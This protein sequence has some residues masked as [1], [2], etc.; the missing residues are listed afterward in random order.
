MIRIRESRARMRGMI[1][2]LIAAVL[3]A[4]CVGDKG[5]APSTRPASETLG[6]ISVSPMN[7][8]MAVGETLPVTT[9]GRSIA[10]AEMTDF[11]SL[12]YQF[13]NAN[14]TGHVHI[15]ASGV[16]TA[17]SASDFYS[18]IRIS[19]FAFKDGVVA[20]DQA[21]IQVVE[22]AFP[23]PTL[24]IAPIAPDSAKM[25]WGDSK[26]L[27]P[28]IQNSASASIPSPQLRLEYGPG[29][30][31]TMQC[32]VPSITATGVLRTPQLQ[33]TRCGQNGNAGTV[34]LNWIHAFTK[35]TAWVHAHV[36]VFGVALHDSVQFTIS[37]PYS[38]GVDVGTSYT[39]SSTH[40]ERSSVYISPGGM[41]YFFNDFN[42]V[43][44]TSVVFTFEHPEA[45]LASDPPATDGGTEGNVSAIL[46]YG[47][48][49][50]KI[51]TPGVYHWT[52]TVSGGIPPYTGAIVKG[53]ITVE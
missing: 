43:L 47:Y 14:D 16:L 33:R 1:P 18:P 11:D 50:R 19:V 20:A 44:G 48:S 15:S 36:T 29:D 28:V 45:M 46:G 53:T 21:I 32:Y 9:T 37:N 6:T 51:V 52:A 10:G 42:P 13:E 27:T 17:I 26:M 8:V 3:L 4:G 39:L 35:G 12:Q 24:S 23:N 7:I 22:T 30:S 49:T 5:V 2:S 25:A 34:Q 38:A 41:V 31:V 40:D